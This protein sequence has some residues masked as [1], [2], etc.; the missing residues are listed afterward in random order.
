[1]RRELWEKVL[2]EVGDKKLA[3]TVFFHQLGEPLL[4]PE[5]FEAIEFAILQGLS[6][7]L[8]TNGALLDEKHSDRLIRSLTKGR[9]VLSLQDIRPEAFE[10]RSRGAM[11]W[12]EYV[13]RI[14][15]FLV[16]ADIAGLPVQVHCLA[17]VRA[18]GWDA[19]KALEEH[20]AIKRVYG[21]FAK[22][23]GGKAGHIN[24]LNPLKAYPLGR[25]STFYIKHR[26]TWDNQMVPPGME[27]VKN[28]RGHCSVMRDTFVVQADGRCTFCCCDYEGALDLG[29]A[30]Y[31]SLEDIFYGDKA[32]RIVASEAEGRMIEERCQ[33]CRGRLIDSRTKRPVLDRPFYLEYYYFREHLARYGWGSTI[34]KITA[35]VRRRLIRAKKR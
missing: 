4:H 27:V 2:T 18:I 11:S 33:V 1:M 34:R 10:A 16:K 22:S 5:V 23:L 29:N 24:I 3:R 35:N 19:H 17:D 6:V 12:E 9:V 32:Q 26:G 30:H 20:R 13:A 28:K 14:R 7:S 25:V 15:D 8:Y 31:A 21:G